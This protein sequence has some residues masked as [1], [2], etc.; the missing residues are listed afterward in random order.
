MSLG[1]YSAQAG[2]WVPLIAPVD[3]TGGKTSAAFSTAMYAHASILLAIG[4][5]AAAPGAVTV[6]ACSNA[7]GAGATAIP[8][9]VF[10]CETAAADTLGAKVACTAAGFVP[11]ATDGIFYIIEIDAQQ[12]PQ[13]LPYLQLA[14]ANAA[15]SVIAFAAAL[16]SGARQASDQSAT[17]LV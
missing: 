10:K 5:S 17:V 7:A 11:A 15:N 14:C 6:N 1:F 8:F 16:L 13:G 9:N 12:L 2:H 3:I 4:V